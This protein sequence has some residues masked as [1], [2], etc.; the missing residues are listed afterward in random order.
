MGER[1]D[2]DEIVYGNDCL[3]MF[4]EGKTPKYLYARFSQVQP[5]PDE[6]IPP[7]DRTFKL[8][9]HETYWCHWSYESD[10][11]LVVFDYSVP[12]ERSE[13][14]IAK[15]PA[16]ARFMFRGNE[17]YAI[18]EGHVF[19]NV[20]DECIGEWGATGGIGVLTWKLEALEIMAALNIKPAYDLFMEMRPLVDSNKIYKFCKLKDATNIAIEFESD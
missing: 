3:A 5:C 4:D 11:W 12:L 17:D 2:K 8:T 16:P 20:Q 10:L 6:P 1:M 19:N 18:E 14:T 13:L 7:N 9:Q 15:Q